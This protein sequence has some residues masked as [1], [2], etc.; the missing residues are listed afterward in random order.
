MFL[1][2]KLGV[3]PIQDSVLDLMGTEFDADLEHR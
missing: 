1:A 2:L 3:I